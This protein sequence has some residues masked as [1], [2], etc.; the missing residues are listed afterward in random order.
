MLLGVCVN[1]CYDELKSLCN[2]ST[3]SNRFFFL[4]LIQL[5]TFWTEMF[6]HRWSEK[7]TVF[8]TTLVH[9][10][11]SVIERGFWQVHCGVF[12]CDSLDRCHQAD[13]D[14]RLRIS[15]SVK[16]RFAR[17]ITRRCIRLKYSR[18]LYNN[19]KIS[20]ASICSV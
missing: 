5:V 3:V 13:F 7:L 17:S 6:S 11:T 16:T 10:R 12:I 20:K 4:L 1:V 2:I 15:F 18:K 8:C 9:L 14:V 19:D